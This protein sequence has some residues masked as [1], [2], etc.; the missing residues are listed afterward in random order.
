ENVMRKRIVFEKWEYLCV[1]AIF[2]Y[3]C[4][5]PKKLD[6][7]V[8]DH[9]VAV[10]DGV[11]DQVEGVVALGSADQSG[12]ADTERPAGSE[13]DHD[14]IA[15]VFANRVQVQQAPHKDC[16]A[17]L[18][19]EG[20]VVSQLRIAK[21]RDKVRGH[22]LGNALDLHGLSS[23]PGSHIHWDARIGMLAF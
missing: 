21:A 7:F 20:A 10:I 15:K 4:T 5:L 8:K 2:T 3:G 13:F 12:E 18:R 9:K 23:Q 22:A 1:P 6:H 17:A 19:I 11:I 16:V 14:F